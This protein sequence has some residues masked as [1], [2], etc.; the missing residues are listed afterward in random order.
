MEGTPWCRKKRKH[1][2]DHV[3]WNQVSVYGFH[4]SRSINPIPILSRHH[5]LLKAITFLPIHIYGTLVS[6]LMRFCKSRQRLIGDL[7]DVSQTSSAV[8]DFIKWWTRLCFW[9]PYTWGYCRQQMH[10][11]TLGFFYRFFITLFTLQ[12]QKMDPN[13]KKLKQKVNAKQWRMKNLKQ[14]RIAENLRRKVI[15]FYQ[16]QLP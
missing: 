16:L 12:E 10:F 6:S 9:V 11:S 8:I 3:W 7:I 15:Y 14:V 1:Y 13:I 4:D 5:H 2:L